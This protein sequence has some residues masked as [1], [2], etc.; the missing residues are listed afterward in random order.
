MSD[1]QTDHDVAQ[2]PEDLPPV[3]PPSAGFIVQLFVVPGVIVVAIVAVWLLFGKL[4]TG[5]QDWQSLVVELQHPNEHRRWRGALG[6]SQL[7][8]ADQELGANGQ[9]LAKNRDIAKALA[10]VLTAEIKRG[11]QSEEDL[12]YT[13]FLARTLGLFDVPDVVLPPLQLAMQAGVDREVRKNAIGSVAVM[14]DRF[15]TTGEP[16]DS[17]AILEELVRVSADEDPLIRQLTAFTLGLFTDVS[18]RDRLEVLLD[19]SDGDTRVNA[20]IGLARQGDSRGT[21]VFS[22]VLKEAAQKKPTGSPEEYEQ[23]LS[24]KNALTAI[25]RLAKGMSPDQRQELIALIEPIAEKYDEPQ[26]RILAKS[27]LQSLRAAG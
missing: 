27:A 6:L 14:A 9:Q 18:A 8:K 15:S 3:Q 25:E 19:D 26:I 23:F 1:A 7:L 12:K 24:L 22:D 16:W 17:G 20:A 10:D 4:A 11:G 2:L 5:E 13:A 21:R